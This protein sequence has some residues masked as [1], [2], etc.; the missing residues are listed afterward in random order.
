MI[1][2]VFRSRGVTLR[3]RR[4]FSK[5]RWAVPRSARVPLLVR[6]ELVRLGM[7]RLEL[8]RLGM[9]RLE[10]VRL[11]MVRLGMVR[12]ATPVERQALSFEV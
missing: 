2:R 7:V 12:L 8:V 9:V 11:G 6:L 3:L 4:C 5:S 1:V 10:L